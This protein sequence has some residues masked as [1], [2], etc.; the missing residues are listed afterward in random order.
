MDGFHS[1]LHHIRPFCAHFYLS[2]VLHSL[3][4]LVLLVPCRSPLPFS[5]QCDRL[6]LLLLQS[7]KDVPAFVA[8]LLCSVFVLSL[9]YVLCHRYLLYLFSVLSLFLSLILRLCQQSLSSLPSLIL[10]SVLSLTSLC[11][12]SALSLFSLCYLSVPTLFSFCCFTGIRLDLP[13]HQ[14]L[15]FFSSSLFPSSLLSSFLLLFYILPLP[16]CVRA[17]QPCSLFTLSS[18][19]RRSEECF[20]TTIIPCLLPSPLHRHFSLTLIAFNETSSQP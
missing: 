17:S 5:Y 8:P 12:L 14:D 7:T 18:A 13:Q 2:A 1:N 11:S 9:L 6:H 10:L 3:F 4:R 19:Q 20:P 15:L 16:C